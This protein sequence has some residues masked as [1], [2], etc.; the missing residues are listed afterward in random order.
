MGW[1]LHI[2]CN[3]VDGRDMLGRS[4]VRPW[5]PN[6]ALCILQSVFSE[7]REVLRKT[8]SDLWKEFTEEYAWMDASDLDVRFTRFLLIGPSPPAVRG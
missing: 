7:T 1:I 8:L 3:I 4:P 5:N 2:G 6:M